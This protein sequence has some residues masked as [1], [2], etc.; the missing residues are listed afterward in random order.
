MQWAMLNRDVYLDTMA[1]LGDLRVP[2]PD[3]KVIA[4]HRREYVPVSN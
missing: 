1:G 2:R 4:E 3:A